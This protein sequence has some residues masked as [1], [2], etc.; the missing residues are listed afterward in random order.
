MMQILLTRIFSFSPGIVNVDERTQVA[1]YNWKLHGV[2]TESINFNTAKDKVVLINYWAT[3]CPPC[4]A[5]MPSFQKLYDDYKD[6]VV[7]LFVTTDDDPELNKFMSDKDYN[8]PIYRSLS[9]HPK[10]FISKSIPATYLIDKKGNI[11]I[12]K[13][14]AAN[15]NS[16]KVRETIDQ[17]L[18]E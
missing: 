15:W 2:N 1:S 17:L 8:Y 13:V 9:E 16:D 10:P 6:K 12:D 14:G 4:I 11:I 7:F 18:A 3:W 5:E